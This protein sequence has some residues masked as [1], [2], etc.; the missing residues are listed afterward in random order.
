MVKVLIVDDE[1][2]ARKRLERLLQQIDGVEVV[3]EAGNGF[4][5]I[6]ASEQHQPDII[7][8]DIRMPVMDG[9]SAASKIASAEQLSSGQAPAIIFCTAYDDY[10]LEAFNVNAVGYLLKPVNAKKLAEAISKAQQLNK[11]QL[12]AVAQNTGGEE[13]G[14]ESSG[15]QRT[16]FSIKSN[17]GVELVLFEDIRYFLAEQKYVSIFYRSE[18]GL[19][20]SLIDEPLKELEQMFGQRYFR[21]HRNALVAVAHIQGLERCNEGFRVKIQDVELGPIVSRRHAAALRQLLD[22]L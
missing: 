3:A 15:A 19:R 13:A 21:V 22:D 4:D 5:A 6:T 2:L 14:K 18:G 8:M 7:L 10:A 16:H 11:V 17:R 12:S 1:P 20:E 9:L